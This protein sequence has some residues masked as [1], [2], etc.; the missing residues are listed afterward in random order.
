LFFLQGLGVVFI[1]DWLSLMSPKNN[2]IE[3]VLQH[4]I[5]WLTIL[6]LPFI[7]NNTAASSQDQQQLQHHRSSS[8]S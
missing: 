2:N 3:E 7:S 1:L 8:S 6:C 4:F 5:V